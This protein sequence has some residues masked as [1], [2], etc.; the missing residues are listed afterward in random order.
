MKLTSKLA[1]ASV[2]LLVISTGSAAYAQSD[3]G[4][5]ASARAAVKAQ[6]HRPDFSVASRVK[7]TAT[8]LVGM[9]ESDA[10]RIRAHAEA[11]VTAKAAATASTARKAI[12]YRPAHSDSIRVTGHVAARTTLQR[13]TEKADPPPTRAATDPPASSGQPSASQSDNDSAPSAG[14]SANGSASVG[15][16]GSVR[17][18]SDSGCRRSAVSAG[19]QLVES[20]FTSVS[21]NL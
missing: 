16:S 21:A 18:S 19:I 8:V 9:T 13:R 6:V 14:L 7:Q 1:A 20:I 3:L 11:L 10:N 12:V 15:L 5:S 4:I 2:G 17:G